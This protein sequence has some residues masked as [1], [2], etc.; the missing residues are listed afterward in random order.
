MTTDGRA[1]NA[2]AASNIFRKGAIANCDQSSI[3]SESY[4]LL[5]R[6]NVRDF[7][8]YG[9]VIGKLNGFNYS[10]GD[11]VDHAILRNGQK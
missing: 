5:P 3:A 4:P 2:S 11:Q 1:K 7:T 6:A 10:D 9:I 8:E